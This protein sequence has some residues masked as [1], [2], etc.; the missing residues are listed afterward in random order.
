MLKIKNEIIRKC[1]FCAATYNGG[2]YR[3]NSFSKLCT[4]KGIVQQFTCPYTPE[5]NGVAERL[6][7]TILESARSMIYHANLPLVFWAEACN[8]AVYLHI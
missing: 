7:R 3:S 1:R 2:E 6:N 5:Q 4:E 8:T